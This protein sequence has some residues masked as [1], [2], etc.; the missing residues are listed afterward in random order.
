[1]VRFTSAVAIIGLACLSCPLVVS[2]FQT[3]RPPFLSVSSSFGVPDAPTPKNN[4][5]RTTTRLFESSA[6]SQWMENEKR[7]EEEMDEAAATSSSSSATAV[8]DS[9]QDTT[10][11]TSTSSSSTKKS[12]SSNNNN[13]Y[14]YDN[15]ID[16]TPHL[17][18]SS[19]W[20]ELHGNYILRPPSNNNND[21][22][23]RALIHFLGGALLGAAPQLS[24]RY[25]LERLSSRGYLIVATPYQLSFDHLATCDEVIGKFELVAPDLAK[26]K[27]LPTYSSLC[28]NI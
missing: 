4:N 12:K 22:P 26:R 16:T 19:R 6:A 1:M 7:F 11:T 28:D 9:T 17:D 25:M 14:D 2:S 21:T 20:E 5:V 8:A 3:A 13:E 23:P 15:T 18:P 24:Y 10:S 27:L